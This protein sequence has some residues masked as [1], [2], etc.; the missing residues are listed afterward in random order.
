MIDD[1]DFIFAQSLRGKKCFCW[2]HTNTLG[3]ILRRFPALSVKYILQA[4]KSSKTYE[5]DQ[6]YGRGEREFP[7]PFIIRGNPGIEILG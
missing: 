5:I 1:S 6:I 3:T 4:N 2:C 7:L